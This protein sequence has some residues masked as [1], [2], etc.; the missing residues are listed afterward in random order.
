MRFARSLLPLALLALLAG[1]VG[2]REGAVIGSKDFGESEILSEMIAQL[3]EADGMDVTRRLGVGD[4][5]VNMEA[6]KR[7]ELDA[8]VEYNGTGLVMLGQPPLSDGDAAMARVRELYA[9]LGLTWGERL[10]FENTYGLVMLADR[11]QALGVETI[12]DLAEHAGELT[13]GIDESFAERPVDGFAPM[14]RRYGL[15]FADRNVV[16]AEDRPLLYAN[17]LDGA[18]DVI[19]GFTTDGQIADYG[20]VVLQDDLNFFPAYEAAPLV[21]EED[22]RL[23]AIANRLSGRLDAEL[24]REL[25]RRVDIDGEAPSEVA[26]AALSELGLL[27][28]AAGIDDTQPL[29]VAASASIGAQQAARGLRAARASFPGRRVELTEVADPLAAVAGG[30]ARVAI[31]TSAAFFEEGGGS[32]RREG[33]EAVGRIGEAMVMLATGAEGPRSLDEVATMVTGPQGSDSH[34]IAQDIAS[35]L[36]IE[37]TLA[38][39]EGTNDAL[40][41]ATQSAD[42]AIAV[43]L[44]SPDA[45][46]VA[47]IGAAR[48]FSLDDWD[49]GDNLVRYP[50]LRLARLP[51]PSGNTV[52]TVSTQV[53]MVGPAPVEGEAVGDAGPGASFTPET[54]P[55]SSETVASLNEALTPGGD[56]VGIDPILPLA[57]SLLPALPEGPADVSPSV[58]IAIL[59]FAIIVFLVFLVY[60]MMRPERVVADGADR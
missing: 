1:C 29:V 48:V 59:N 19:E 27:E 18:A 53:V 38:P 20:L 56:G 47:K 10:G 37:V 6:L 43:L 9:P 17:L 51:F 35:G 12:S 16:S 55:L 14:V 26:R 39:T 28:G 4:T 57:A 25:N 44:L 23:L 22:S 33:F 15:E 8:Y 49:R 45:D 21:G 58:D 42:A 13:I 46:A 11:A 36:G 41:E 34:R 60:L 3:A 54:L 31:A 40:L 24:M 5:R 50:Y 30:R 7:G 2:E 32:T 52:E